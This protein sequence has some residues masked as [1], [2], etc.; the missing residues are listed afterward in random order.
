MNGYI[1]LQRD[2]L[3]RNLKIEIM[4]KHLKQLLND[5]KTKSSWSREQLVDIIQRKIADEEGEVG[6]MS[7]KDVE[8]GDITII[9]LHKMPHPAIVI[10]IE[11]D[12]CTCV[13]LSS[14]EGDHCVF[15]IDERTITSWVTSTITKSP[16][17]EVLKRW[18]GAYFS[19]KQVAE[20][21][22]A[23]KK[24]YKEEFIKANF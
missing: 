3:K 11:G 21:K 16:K 23:L 20:I 22:A 6:R 15:K 14:T 12:S 9:D 2:S 17:E 19:K 1:V 13:V 7:P 4:S 5:V 10:A 24:Y 18:K 8:V